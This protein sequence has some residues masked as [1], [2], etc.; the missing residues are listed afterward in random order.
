MNFIQRMMVKAFGS[1]SFRVIIPHN[2]VFSTSSMGAD[3]Y[4]YADK[5]YGGNVYVFSVIN[6]IASK[7]KSIPWSVY[8]VKKSAEKQFRGYLLK[9]A[10]GTN[11]LTREVR[12]LK[13]ASLEEVDGHKLNE[14][15]ERPNPLQPW[16]EYISSVLSFKLIAGNSFVVGIGPD[17][18][19]NA[20]KFTELFPY[21]P[22]YVKIKQERDYPAPVA[23]YRFDDI[24]QDFP[25]EQVLHIKTFH[26]LQPRIG[27]S[28]IEAAL[29][30]VRQSNSYSQWNEQLTKNM[31]GIPIVI[32][33]DNDNLTQEQ[34]QQMLKDFDERQAGERN[35]GKPFITKGKGVSVQQISVSPKDMEWTRG[36]QLTANQIALAFEWPPELVGDTETKTFDNMR[37][38]LKLAYN[39]KVIPEMDDMRDAFNNFFVKQWNEGNNKYYIDYNLEDI[40]ILQEDRTAVWE[41]T[42]S[43]WSNGLLTLDEARSEIGFDAVGGEEGEQ[44]QTPIGLLGGGFGDSDEFDKAMKRLKEKGVTHYTEV[45]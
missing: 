4:S 6:Q 20:G 5:G 41:R 42:G 33:V 17:T 2:Q 3:T 19:D 30:S 13:Q 36:M 24:Q 23:G 10:K 16:S 27:M 40:E 34:V 9:T 22:F 38:M 35:A 21:K 11:K 14:I 18:G 26:P 15:L 31:G 44:R 32:T 45:N 37:A 1:G 39:G 43:A 7:C 25:V 29:L 28:P 12:Q 8:R